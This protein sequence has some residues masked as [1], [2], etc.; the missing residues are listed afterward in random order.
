MNQLSFTKQLSYGM[1]AS[2]TIPFQIT[3]LFYNFEILTQFLKVIA[4]NC[5]F[6]LTNYVYNQ[7]YTLL[8]NYSFNI[9]KYLVMILYTLIWFVPAYLCIYVISFDKLGYILS[10]IHEKT[11]LHGTG[12]CHGHEHK[13]ETIYSKLY[14]VLVSCV[15]YMIIGFAAYI[16]TVIGSVISFIA[17]SYSYSYAC[18]EYCCNF[19]KITNIE[20]LTLI[21][22]DPYFFIGYGLMYG[23]FINYFATYVNFFL[24]FVILFP[25]GIL[26]LSQYKNQ[27]QLKTNT[28]HSIVFLIPAIISNTILSIIDSSLMSYQNLQ[29]AKKATTSSDNGK[30]NSEQDLKETNDKQDSKKTNDDQKKNK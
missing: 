27:F 20:K 11:D 25:L 8:D 29:E 2:F 19:K 16:P 7:F 10:R 12:Y 13:N 5:V 28:H 23:F 6:I 1:L 30:Q 26:N 17:I 14:F 4:L 22:Y 21:D 18:L 3:K 24:V 15:F 9:M